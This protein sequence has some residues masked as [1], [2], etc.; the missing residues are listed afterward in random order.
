[1]DCEHLPKIN[2]EGEEARCGRANK[3]SFAWREPPFLEEEVEEL[4]RR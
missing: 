3:H 2:W 4:L 1:L